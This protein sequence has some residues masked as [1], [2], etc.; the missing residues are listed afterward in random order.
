MTPSSGNVSGPPSFVAKPPV[1][2]DFPTFGES[3]DTPAVLSFIEQCENF[4]SL[5]PLSDAELIATLSTVL[6][7]SAKSWW[8]AEKT[9]IHNWTEFKHS[10]LS[11]FLPTDYLT[12]VE[13]QLRVSVQA[14]DQSIRDFAY[15]YRALCLKWKPDMTEIGRAHV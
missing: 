2:L 6:K 12:E 15:D 7:Q 13:E 1:R 3:R 10:F 14:P 4:L 11:A 8:M 9:K 5:R